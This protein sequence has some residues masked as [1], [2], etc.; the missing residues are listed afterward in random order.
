MTENECKEIYISKYLTVKEC[1]G[2]I[3]VLSIAT[4]TTEMINYVIIDC[5]ERCP[6]L[7]FSV[8]GRNIE[9]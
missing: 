4:E 9:Y 3:I 2:G 8:W 7:Y 6:K 1:T 5:T